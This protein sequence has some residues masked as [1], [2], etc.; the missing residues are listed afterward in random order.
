MSTGVK[1]IN[2][3]RNFEPVLDAEFYVSIPD[4]TELTVCL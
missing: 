3:E 4:L 2:F 1:V